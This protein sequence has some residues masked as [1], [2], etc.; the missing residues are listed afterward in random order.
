MELHPAGHYTAIDGVKF[1]SVINGASNTNEFVIFF[2]ETNNAFT[3]EGEPALLPGDVVIVDNAPFHHHEA[4]VLLT[5][6]FDGQGV[7]LI[8]LPTYSP[9][10]N[11]AENCFN[12]LKSLLKRDSY[13]TLLHENLAVAVYDAVSLITPEDTHQYFLDTDYIHT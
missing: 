7:E 1:S 2:V 9:D 10:F 13:R 8:Y 4:E 3:D 6:Y 5:N 12:K 11:P